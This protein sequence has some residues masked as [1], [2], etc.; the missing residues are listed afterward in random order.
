MGSD[1]LSRD[2]PRATERCRELCTHS[3]CMTVSRPVLNSTTREGKKALRWSH[4]LLKPGNGCFVTYP[5]CSSQ[6]PRSVLQQAEG[7]RKVYF[8]MPLFL[9][10]F[11][12]LFY[13][14][15]PNTGFSS[16][17][18]STWALMKLVRATPAC[19]TP[20]HLGFTR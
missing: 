1:C 12:V 13:F 16:G 18:L 20:V 10:L 11:K 14:T 17:Q 3:E 2:P 5:S 8:G 4:H 19:L 7:Q 15:S 9:P 6:K